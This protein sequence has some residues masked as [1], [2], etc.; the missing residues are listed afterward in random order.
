MRVYFHD[1]IYAPIHDTICSKLPLI[2]GQ[3]ALYF[4]MLFSMTIT[5]SYHQK[6]LVATFFAVLPQIDSTIRRAHGG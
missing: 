4:N 3:N 2:S 1:T 6:T 5:T